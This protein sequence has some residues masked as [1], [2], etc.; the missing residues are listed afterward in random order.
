[1]SS[2]GGHVDYRGKKLGDGPKWPSQVRYKIDL[3]DTIRREIAPAVKTGNKNR[4]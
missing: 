3:A 4:G 1:M 2:Y